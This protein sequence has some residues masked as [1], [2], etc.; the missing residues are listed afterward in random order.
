[1]R[2]RSGTPAQAVALQVLALAAIAASGPLINPSRLSAQEATIT[3]RVTD[4]ETGAA[5][6][7]AAVENCARGL[8]T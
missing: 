2:L 4:L 7:D 3:G 8:Q 1:M 6:S 5:V